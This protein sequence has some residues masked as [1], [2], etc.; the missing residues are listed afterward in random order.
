M[1][2]LSRFTPALP[3]IFALLLLVLPASGQD[4]AGRVLIIQGEYEGST[5][6]VRDM[7][8]DYAAPMQHQILPLLHQH[9]VPF[10]FNPTAPFDAALQQVNGPLVATTSGLNILGLGK[11]F[12]G[13]TICCVPPDTNAA[14]GAT[15]VVETVNLS[16]V[17]FSKST[18]AK[19]AGPFL[20]SKLFSGAANSCASGAMTDPVVEYDRI[21]ARWVITYAAATSIPTSGP[22]LQCISVSTSSDATGSYHSYSFDLT[23]LGGFNDYGKLGIWTD[24]YYMSF[25]EFTTGGASLGAAPCA[26]QGSAMRAG[27][28]ASAVCF[29]PMSTQ[30]TLLPAQID[31]P[32]LPV[33]GE[34]EFYVGSLDGSSHIHLA[35]F[36]VNFST[37]SLSTFKVLALTVAAYKEACSG[38]TCIPQPSGGELLESGADRM[39]FRAAYRKF[40]GTGAH[41]SIVTNHTVVAGSASGV[42]WYEIRNPNGTTP[43]IFQQGTFAP[44]D[45][46]FRWMGSI[47]MDKNGDIALGYSVSSASL[48]PSIR[49]TGRLPTDPAG[50]MEAEKSIVTGTGVQSSSGHRW[51]DYSS[52]A[53]DPGDD[54]T[55]WYTQEYIKTG[56]SFSW[57]T[58]LASFHFNTCP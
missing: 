14:V 9:P 21:N 31:G 35:R 36:H 50:T 55:F 33:T 11:G 49:Y 23:A 40:T 19:V 4:F 32:N 17:I 15:Q 57:S 12:T 39:M 8:P 10:N 24:A 46:K 5:A 7:V 52:M 22:F 28:P 25:N 43:T 38:G 26:L 44:A 41:E 45:G 37:P 53:I 20:V 42:R 18:G 54:C 47:G 6:A 48:D 3:A 2:K 16:F 30:F 29:Q 34:P 27:T 51:G 58:R 56:G 1:K 13:Y